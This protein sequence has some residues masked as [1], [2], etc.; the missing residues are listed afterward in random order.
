[1]RRVLAVGAHPDDLEIGAG[2]TLL[3]HVACGDQVQLLVLTAGQ[4]GAGL[5]GTRRAEA[6]AAAL[7]LGAS[8]TVAGL[9]DTLVG[10]KAAIDAIEAA[11]SGFQPD[12][13][14]IHSG[15]DTHQDH[16]TIAVASRVA[17]RGVCKLY[18]FQAPSATTGFRPSRFTDISE[19]LGG[20]QVL[21]KHHRS[22]DR[23]HYMQP[24]FAGA[25]ARYWGLRTGNCP[26][27][28]AFEVIWD[29]DFSPHEF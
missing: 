8:I 12:T 28:E 27:A 6:E 10:E 24:E 11:T 18:A 20:K 21:L 7:W 2:G 3:K 19:H 15:H 1:M 25:T 16:R 9:P 4:A 14:Y 13:A 26:A 22:Q 23:R 5:P 29:R 17:L